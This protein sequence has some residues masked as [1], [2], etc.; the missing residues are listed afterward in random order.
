[1]RAFSLV[2][3]QGREAFLLGFLRLAVC[4]IDGYKWRVGLICGVL[5]SNEC[6]GNPKGCKKGKSGGMHIYAYY[7]N[8]KGNK[9][10]GDEY[11]FKSGSKAMMVKP[12]QDYR[13]RLVVKL[14]TGSAPPHS[15]LNRCH[16]IV[17]LVEHILVTDPR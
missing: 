10:C 7:S 3:D 6:Q 16:L 5:C 17:M 13:I 15:D 9:G 1:M 12:N 8:M 4:C 11:T 14:N 2:Y